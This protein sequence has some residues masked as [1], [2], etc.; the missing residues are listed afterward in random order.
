MSLNAKVKSI[1]ALQ[2][3]KGALKRF[4]DDTW[5]ALRSAEQKI[6]RTEELLE[7]RSNHW[8][9]KVE[10]YCEDV[11][12]AKRDLQYCRDEE[13]N[14]CSV[15]E[16]ALVEAKL[17]LRNAEAELDNVRRWSI[18]FDKIT[19]DYRVQAERLK[20][21]LAVEMPRADAS[22]GRTI[23]S[24]CSYVERIQSSEQV[25]FDE[26]VHGLSADID[27]KW[28]IEGSPEETRELYT[29]LNKLAQTEKGRASAE[30]IQNHGTTMKFG[31]LPKKYVCV[32][33]PVDNEIVVNLNCR[34]RSASVLAAYLAHEGTHVEWNHGN[35]KPSLN[36]EYYSFKT[37]IEVWQE[38]KGN[39][40]DPLCDDWAKITAEGEYISKLKILEIYGQD[41]FMGF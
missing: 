26:F 23:A 13:D 40:H 16:E 3:W 32:Y 19:A 14:D 41:Y 9:H 10:Q 17:H 8:R 33:Y 4:V 5:Q 18:R 21:F 37:Q 31:Y 2:E 11:L 30:A 39:E 34:A 12:Q 22:M 20:Q 36:E 27:S 15:E 29:A 38:V 35:P 7:E 24:L 6:Q 28:K 25:L 1:E